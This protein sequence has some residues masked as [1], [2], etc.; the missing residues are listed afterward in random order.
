MLKTAYS[1]F[2]SA[3]RSN[4]SMN[5]NAFTVILIN[6]CCWTLKMLKTAYSTFRSAIRSNFSMNYNAFTVILINACCWTLKMLK[7][8][9]ST[10]RSAIRAKYGASIYLYSDSQKL[11]KAC[12]VMLIAIICVLNNFSMKYSASIPVYNE[13]EKLY[14][15]YLVMFIAI[16]VRLKVR[17]ESCWGYTDFANGVFWYWDDLEMFFSIV[18]LWNCRDVSTAFGI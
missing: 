10:F 15:A 16:I 3:I 8:A 5:Y 12:V 13:S 2:R 4:F 9:Y 1:T 17:L 11:Q 6:A 14:K 7:T 18:V